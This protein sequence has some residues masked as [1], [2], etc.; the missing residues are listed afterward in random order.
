MPRRT[1]SLTRSGLVRGVVKALTLFTPAYRT[2]APENMD[3]AYRHLGVAS[4]DLVMVKMLLG[5]L[6]Q[7]LTS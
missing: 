3:D 1:S 7:E 5:N 6:Q 2:F 4:A